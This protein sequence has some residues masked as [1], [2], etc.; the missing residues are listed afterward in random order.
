MAGKFL[1]SC[2]VFFSLYSTGC[3]TESKNIGSVNTNGGKISAQAWCAGGR[4]IGQ[5]GL[6]VVLPSEI[7]WADR[8]RIPVRIYNRGTAGLWI[9]ANFNLRFRDNLPQDGQFEVL[10]KGQ[11]SSP[12]EHLGTRDI[13]FPSKAVYRVLSPGAHVESVLILDAAEF[14]IGPGLFLLTLCYDD[15][16][17]NIPAP[18]PGAVQ[19]VSKIVSRELVVKKE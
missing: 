1:V 9:P 4:E 14:S 2:F 10:L 18:P 12:A 6:Q 8:L 17:E 13:I 7:V 15:Q 19:E 11:N 3:F 5:S 16:T